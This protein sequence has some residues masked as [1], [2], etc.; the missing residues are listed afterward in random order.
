MRTGNW[1]SQ[2]Y[3]Q[4][5]DSSPGLLTSSPRSAHCSVLS[6]HAQDNDR[7]GDKTTHK[8]SDRDRKC[9]EQMK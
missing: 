6:W 2:G 8:V 9:Y 4:T 1:V 3:W 5:W 7:E